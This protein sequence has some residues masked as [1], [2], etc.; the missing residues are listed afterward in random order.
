MSIFNSQQLITESPTITLHSILGHPLSYIV[1]RETVV[2]ELWSYKKATEPEKQWKFLRLVT[3][4]EPAYVV[5]SATG[6]AI[7]RKQRSKAEA[8]RL[9]DW[10]QQ[11]GW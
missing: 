11:T 8:G 1:Q 5:P 9:A 4:E 2:T 10:M 6:T 7:R 3:Q